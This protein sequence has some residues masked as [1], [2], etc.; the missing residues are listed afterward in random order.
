MLTDGLQIM[1]IGMSVVFLVLAF[2]VLA[3]WLSSSVIRAMGM[4]RPQ[5]QG[6]LSPAA[7]A[8]RLHG[9]AAAAITAAL[10]RFRRERKG[11]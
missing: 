11:Q 3:T 4:D 2:I 7:A 9:A 1:V 5:A 8:A 10:D 6:S